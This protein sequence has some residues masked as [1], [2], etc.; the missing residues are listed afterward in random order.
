MKFYPFQNVI[1]IDG[2]CYSN[3]DYYQT[4]MMSATFLSHENLTAT[5]VCS[6][7]FYHK[8]SVCFELFVLS[9]FLSRFLGRF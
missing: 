5:S 1:A 6:V 2:L 3:K 8:I 4:I 7:F 9:R